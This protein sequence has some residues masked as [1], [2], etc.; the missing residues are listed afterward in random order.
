[1]LDGFCAVCCNGLVLKVILECVLNM[2]AVVIEKELG[3]MPTKEEMEVVD[4]LVLNRVPERF[5]RFLAPRRVRGS[6][7]PDILVDG[8]VWEIK[9]IE[10]LGRNTIEHAGRKGLKQ[11]SNLIFDLRR[12]NVVLERK[13]I[14]RL[15]KNFEMVKD[16]RG[17]VVIVRPGGKCL[18]FRK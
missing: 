17:L 3:A 1:M 12:L 13:A 7:N 5:V 18:L 10:R 16:W 2:S 6:K 8:V 4:I 11:A 15:R 14:A 9:T